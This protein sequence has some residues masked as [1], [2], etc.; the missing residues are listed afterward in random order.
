MS[1]SEEKEEAQ[2][3]AQEGLEFF[4][5]LKGFFTKNPKALIWFL[6]VVADE[7]DEAIR[8][9]EGLT[10]EI[11]H[12]TGRINTVHELFWDT[13]HRDIVLNAIAEPLITERLM[14]AV[15]SL[16]NAYTLVKD[17][18]NIDTSTLDNYLDDALT[19]LYTTLRAVIDKADQRACQDP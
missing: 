2:V 8:N 6:H 18:N 12:T 15:A 4:G 3:D 10:N 5:A 19:L 11:H 13:D 9:A 14:K 7:A 17:N 16:A 1:E